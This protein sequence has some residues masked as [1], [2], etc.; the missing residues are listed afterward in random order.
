MCNNTL[1]YS[2]EK[3]RQ[4]QQG[5]RDRAVHIPCK[6]GTHLV[7]KSGPLFF[8]FAD[9]NI[10]GIINMHCED[11]IL[12]I[13]CNTLEV[14]S[15]HLDSMLLFILYNASAIFGPNQQSL[16]ELMKEP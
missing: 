2:F 8:F 3:N 5:S 16:I 14:R 6:K 9:F 13:N 7:I 15:S 12:V 4:I 11:I 1:C 10:T